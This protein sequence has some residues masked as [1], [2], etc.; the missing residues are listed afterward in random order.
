[1]VNQKCWICGKPADT[2]EHTVK[3]SDLIRISGSKFFEKNNRLVKHTAD[4]RIIIQG[5]DSKYVKYEKSL[6]KKC[7]NEVTQPYDRAYDLFICLIIENCNILNTKKKRF[8]KIYPHDTKVHQLNLFKYFVKSFGCQLIENGEK[9]PLD[10]V[11][12]LNGKDKKHKLILAFSIRDDI[13]NNDNSFF[14]FYQVHNL[15][16]LKDTDTGKDVKFIWAETIGWL[17]ISYWHN[18]MPE[19]YVG[20]MWV[21]QSKRIVLGQCE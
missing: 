21:G 5:P 15:E 4:K 18:C 9:V 14:K 20:S 11:N 10:L 7:N 13:P 16:R 8:N 19:N 3:K 6:C 17:R 1:M 2:A 12:F